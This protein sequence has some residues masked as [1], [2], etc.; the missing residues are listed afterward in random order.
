MGVVSSAG[1]VA[2][3]DDGDDSGFRFLDIFSLKLVGVVKPSF[4]VF[5]VVI[6]VLVFAN[7]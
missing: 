1:V 4:F 6:N 5:F 7:E 3:G 2:V